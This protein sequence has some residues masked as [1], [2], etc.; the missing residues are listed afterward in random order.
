MHLLTSDEYK[1]LIEKAFKY[2]LNTQTED[3]IEGGAGER[4]LKIAKQP[5][6]EVEDK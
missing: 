4:K 5:H 1:N 2:P 6:L 3:I